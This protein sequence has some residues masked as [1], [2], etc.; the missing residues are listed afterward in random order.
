MHKYKF[1]FVSKFV[2]DIMAVVICEVR[3]SE[4]LSFLFVTGLSS[5]L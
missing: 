5:K 3:S 2:A 1:L 4:R